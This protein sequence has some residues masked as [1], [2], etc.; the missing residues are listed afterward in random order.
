MHISVLALLGLLPFVL[1]GYLPLVTQILITGLFALSL[2]VALGYAGILTVGHAAFLGAGAYA[3][4]LFSLHVWP[5]P[6]T[7]LA[8]GCATGALLGYLS[9]VLIVRGADLTRLMITIGFGLLLYEAANQ[10]GHITGGADGL[11]GISIAPLFGVFRF[12]LAGKTAYV[13]CL[14][15]VVLAVALSAVV[16]RSPFGMALQ[17]IRQNKKRMDALGSNVHSRL[18]MAYCI[19]AALAATAGA[20]MVQTTQFV[21]IDSLS[22]ARSAEILIVLILGGTGRLYGGLVGAAVFVLVHDALSHYEP[23]YWMVGLGIFLIVF[24]LVDK[25]GGLWSVVSRSTGGRG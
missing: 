17:G 14:V 3:A 8:A 24:V 22:F 19:S 20:L 15:V 12:D 1:P 25:G 2:D 10:L 9:S 16:L 5:E 13:Y 21:G 7:G 4:G 11:Q 6:L 23:Q 18:R